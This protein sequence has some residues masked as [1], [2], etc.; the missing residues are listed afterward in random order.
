VNP[1]KHRVS[2]IVD[3]ARCFLHVVS[4]KAA[5]QLKQVDEKM[6]Q[7]TTSVRTSYHRFRPLPTSVP[8]S[9]ILPS[10]KPNQCNYHTQEGLTG[11]MAYEPRRGNIVA[12]VFDDGENGALWYVRTLV[13][14]CDRLSSPP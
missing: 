7:L 11:K 5:E 13:F 6:K 4:G 12:A 1:Q 14:V 10:S 2:E 9:L 3:G 8:L